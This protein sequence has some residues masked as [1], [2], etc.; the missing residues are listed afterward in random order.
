MEP[1]HVTSG[2]GWTA[3]FSA[4]S[5]ITLL[6]ILIKQL[7]PWRK[8]KVGADEKLRDDLLHRVETLERQLLR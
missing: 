5:F 3:G 4:A 7:G 1:I 6:G 2:F 8:I